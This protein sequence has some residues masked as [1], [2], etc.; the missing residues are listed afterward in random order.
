MPQAKHIFG[1]S[2]N[3][4]DALINAAAGVLEDAKAKGHDGVV[5][6]AIKTAAIAYTAQQM[7][8]MRRDAELQHKLDLSEAGAEG[9][10]IAGLTLKEFIERFSPPSAGGY[11]LVQVHDDGINHHF[12]TSPLASDRVKRAMDI[13]LQATDQVS[14]Y[15]TAMLPADPLPEKEK[16]N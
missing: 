16:V 4:V 13:M 7:L 11:V 3:D 10:K 2:K 12:G 5:L 1:F 6:E 14:A 9:G 15:C 8:L